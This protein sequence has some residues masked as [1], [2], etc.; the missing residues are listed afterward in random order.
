MDWEWLQARNLS[1]AD[2]DYAYAYNLAVDNANYARDLE[3]RLRDADEHINSAEMAYRDERRRASNL[4]ERIVTGAAANERMQD[5]IAGLRSDINELRNSGLRFIAERDAY[6][7]Q[8]EVARY[9]AEHFHRVHCSEPH[10]I[11]WEHSTKVDTVYIGEGHH[12]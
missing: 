8:L 7:A 4:E 10:T 11:D 1:D 9:H 2:I 12:L 3:S 6:K 5:T